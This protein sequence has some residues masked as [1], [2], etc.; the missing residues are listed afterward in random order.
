MYIH[1]YSYVYIYICIH[2][3]IFIN[4]CI[5][6]YTI[7]CVCVFTVNEFDSSKCRALVIRSGCHNDSLLRL[8]RFFM[9]IVFLHEHSESPKQVSDETDPKIPCKG[10]V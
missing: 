10:L 7:A 2:V 3:G 5:H 8:Y 6:I 1:V 9:R 4:M